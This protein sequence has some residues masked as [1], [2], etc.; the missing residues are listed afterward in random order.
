MH[1]DQAKETFIYQQTEASIKWLSQFS[2]SDGEG[3]TRLVYTNPWLLAQSAL[4]EKCEAMGLETRMDPA[5]N[6]F[7]SF[8]GNEQGVVLTGSHIDTVKNGGKY[9]GAYGIVAGLVAIKFLQEYLGIPK[10]TIELVSFCEEEGS[11]YPLTFWGSRLITEE[12]DAIPSVQEDKGHI[13][14]KEAMNDVGLSIDELSLIKKR[15]DIQA[16]IELHV[17]QGMRLEANEKQ[18]GVVE[19]IAGVHRFTVT[20][21]GQAN[22]AGTTPMTMRQDAV[23]G[24]SQMIQWVTEQ[25][26]QYGEPFVATVGQM[27][28]KP[29]VPNVIANEVTFTVDVRS[30]Q[31][32]TLQ[33][34]KEEM[35]TVFKKIAVVNDL[36][37]VVE[38]WLATPPIM[39]DSE[40]TATAKAICDEQQLSY[41][42]MT[43]GAG[44]DAQIMA[45]HYH[46]ALLFVPSYR[47]I[48]HSPLEHTSTADLAAGVKVLVEL[49]YRLAY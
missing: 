10:K 18:I 26:K 38:Q 25:A 19:Q 27:S 29:N 45:K 49:L 16:F 36:D 23:Y 13:T 46:T 33:T 6:V 9:D 24:A 34:F 2:N 43:S 21:T 15:N 17:E 37:I 28:V 30:P 3:V 22:H 47:G 7:A 41:Q 39:M 11:R 44:H 1:W 32:D 12:V 4:Q 48:S 31:P 14:L 35:T 40:L 20:V 42:M 8:K 5:G